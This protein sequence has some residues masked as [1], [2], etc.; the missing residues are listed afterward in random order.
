[1]S[2]RKEFAAAAR[3]NL[4][5]NYNFVTVEPRIV[6]S[7]AGELD[8]ARPF[9]DGLSGELSVRWT[10]ETPLC[11]GGSEDNNSPFT[12]RGPDDF[13]IPG[14]SLRG[15]VRSTLEILSYARLSFVNGDQYFGLR[16][17]Q[18]P[19]WSGRMGRFG[20]IYKAG[21]LFRE[22]QNWKLEEARFEKVPVAAIA[23]VLGI[24]EDQWHDATLAKRHEKLR[25]AGLDGV[26]SLRRFGL[27]FGEESGRLVVSGPTPPGNARKGKM[28]KTNEAAFVEPHPD[29]PRRIHDVSQATFN[30][31]RTAEPNEGDGASGGV[32]GDARY[33]WTYWE[34]LLKSDPKLRIPVFYLG[35]A[36]RA[37]EDRPAPD[38]VMGLSRFMRMPYL[39]SVGDVAAATQ[40]DTAPG[41]L[42]FCQALFGHVPDEESDAPAGRAW[43]SRVFF[44]M[45]ELDPAAPLSSSDFRTETSATMGPKASF[46][47]FYLRPAPGGEKAVHPLDYNNEAARLAGR[48]RYPARGT[49]APPHRSKSDATQS[50]ISFL[51]GGGRAVFTGRVRFANLRPAELGG[52]VWALSHGRFGRGENPYRHMLGRAKAYG[53]GQMRVEIEAGESRV[54][55]NDGAGPAPDLTRCMELFESYMLEQLAVQGTGAAAFCGLL[56]VREFLALCDPALGGALAPEL[57]WPTAKAS[58]DADPV[59]AGYMDVRSRTIARERRGQPVG[60]DPLTLPAYPTEPG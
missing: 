12:L 39:K 53:F 33:N 24:T 37:A 59:V 21:W 19:S 6:P 30:R 54:R 52:L 46:Y 40:P 48:K 35:D 41:T 3:K 56:P 9:A 20:H 29:D 50:T 25:A 49:T 60:E 58:N 14:A 1:M 23:R 27:S 7:L 51:P 22:G 47:P 43:R 26:V 38:F 34:R 2:S 11:V 57:T 44:S 16:D 5:A 55:R 31:F 13:A 32:P 42:D 10:A 45:A 18:H 28:A 17:H 15:L 4:R 8:R 36:A